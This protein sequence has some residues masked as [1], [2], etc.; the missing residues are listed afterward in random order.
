MNFEFLGQIFEKY[1][2]ITCHE[3]PP[4]AAKLFHVDRRTDMTKLVITFR[5]FANAPK[6]KKLA[7][8]YS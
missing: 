4:G 1:S 6:K 7:R 8:V 2:N 5:S 3:N